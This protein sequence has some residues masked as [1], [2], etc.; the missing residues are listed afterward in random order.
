MDGVNKRTEYRGQSTEYRV[1]ENTRADARVQLRRKRDVSVR[2]E[3][4]RK[5]G[6]GKRKKIPELGHY[7]QTK[8]F[9]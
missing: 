8:K 4:K 9:E 6:K 2:A 5:K 3:S 7:A 1:K